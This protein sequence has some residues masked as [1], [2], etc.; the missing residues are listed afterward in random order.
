MDRAGPGVF[1][2]RIE[3]TKLKP[4]LSDDELADLYRPQLLPC[5]FCG[6]QEFLDM[7]TTNPNA[8][9][10]ECVSCGANTDSDSSTELAV[11]KWNRRE[12]PLADKQAAIKKA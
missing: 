12:Q 1:F 11:K 3:M 4:I 8:F 10:V 7:V 6:L 5:P 2:R 9:W